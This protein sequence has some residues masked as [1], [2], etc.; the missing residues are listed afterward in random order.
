[1]SSINIEN[2]ITVAASNDDE[3]KD[4]SVQEAEAAVRTLLE[5]IGE[6]PE[7][8][9]LRETPARVIK[10]F[11]EFYRGY[12]QSPKDILQKTFTDIDYDDYVMVKNIDF[13]AHCEH[14][15]V[16]VIGKVHIAYWP[17]SHVVGISKL[18]RLVDV[19]ARRL[20]TQEQMTSNIAKALDEELNSKGSA[21][22]IDAVHHCMS[23]RGV[24]KVD[25]S[26]VTSSFTGI[27]KEEEP[28]RHR[29]LTNIK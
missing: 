16:P 23:Y 4:V 25:S 24:Q 6:N 14:H 29:F 2:Q 22:V 28:L 26:T 11:E 1:M 27:F 8:D 13:M 7:R 18:A 15:M 5:Y 12:K 9:G 3:R 17:Q 21:V 10:S 19:F 20:I